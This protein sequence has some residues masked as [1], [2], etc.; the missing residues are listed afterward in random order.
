MRNVTI[1][2]LVLLLILGVVKWKE[3]RQGDRSF[4][5]YVVKLDSSKVETLTFI[6]K[7]SD[8]K[9]KLVKKNDTWMLKLEDK[10]V[11]A[12]QGTILDLLDQLT[13]LKTKVVAA[14][15]KSKWA[16]YE[17][18]DSLATRIIV[19]EGK[20]PLVDLL[21]GKFSYQQPKGQNPYMQQQNI[22]MTSYVRLNGENEVYAVDGYLSMMI[23]RQAKTYR[24]NSI[25]TGNPEN[26][27]K[28]IFTYPGD[29]SFNL[30]KQNNVWM[31]DGAIA[32]STK[33]DNYLSKIRMLTDNNYADGVEVDLNEKA[34]YSVRIEGDNISPINIK[35]YYHSQDQFLTVSS[36]NKGNVFESDKAKRVL[37]VPKDSLVVR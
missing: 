26:W 14:Q 30:I 19:N 11:Q 34:D 9:V 32:D 20:K 29:S 37:F 18:T 8:E 35:G 25:L 33:V 2:L 12:D 15:S 16:D 24:D 22:K 3:S 7:N 36:Q 23:N 10:M 13:A 1:I 17:V 6:P 31:V 5:E 27:K 21:V 28:L 4:K